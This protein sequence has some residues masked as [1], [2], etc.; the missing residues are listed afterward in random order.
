MPA[1]LLYVSAMLPMR[2]ETFVY[3]E[4]LALRDRGWAV[5]GVSVNAPDRDLGDPLLDALADETIKVYPDGPL[6]MFGRALREAVA[7]PART[8][9]TVAFALRCATSGDDVSGLKRLKVLWQTVGALSVAEEARRR[10]VTYVHAQMAH[11]P[12]TV[13]LMLARQ[14]EVPFSFTGHAVDL[15]RERTLLRTKLQH[16]RF[17]ACISYWHRDFYRGI[18]P[19]TDEQL[20]IVRCGVSVDRFKPEPRPHRDELHIVAVG[21]LIEKKGFDLLLQALAALSEMPG[22]E[23]RWRCTIAGDGADA[24]ALRALSRDL[25]L[26]DRVTFTGAVAHSTVHTY[27]QGA[28]IFV[29]PCRVAASGDRDGIPVV[30]MEAMACEAPVV[31]GDIPSIRELVIDHETGLLV[32]PESVDALADALATLAGDPDLRRTLAQMGRRRV[33]EEFSD[34]K[35]IDRLEAALQ[36]FHPP[37]D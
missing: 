24:N 11:V 8:L 33:L 17:C 22:P 27:M 25:G 28:D 31:A 14:L 12:A 30:L 19:K 23:P 34:R 16:A 15:F 3:R 32:E 36:R 37:T 20:P 4:L 10:G 2:T 13:A 26:D 7:H 21:R 6:A 35:N 1:H 18:V 9:A 29:L 5:S